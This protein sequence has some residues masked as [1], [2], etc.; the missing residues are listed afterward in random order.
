MSLYKLLAVALSVVFFSVAPTAYAATTASATSTCPVPVLYPFTLTGAALNTPWSLPLIGTIEGFNNT[1]VTATGLPPGIK[2]EDQKIEL[3]STSFKLHNWVLTGSPTQLGTYTINVTAQNSCGGTSTIITLPIN[4]SVSTVCP[5]G[6]TGQYPNCAPGTGPRV[7]IDPSAASFATPNPI[8]TGT[9]NTSSISITLQDS[10]GKRYNSQVV[11][12]VGARW[13]VPFYNLAGGTYDLYL[14][15]GD[16]NLLIPSRL[17]I[18]L[19]SAAT[20]VPPTSTSLSVSTP[21][22]TA[23]GACMSIQSTLRLGSRGTDVTALQNFLIGKGLLAGGSA[24]GYFGS[25][26][27]AA[28]QK[29]Q[30]GQ[31]LASSGDE[32][33][34]GYGLVGARTRAAIGCQSGSTSSS[35]QSAPRITCPAYPQP[36]CGVGSTLLGLGHD[37]NGCSM[38][39]QCLSQDAQQNIQVRGSISC[40]A[41]R[42]PVCYENDKPISL[43]TDANGCSLGSYCEQLSPATPV[44]L[45][46]QIGYHT[47]G[48]S[49][50]ANTATVLFFA[51][52]MSGTAPFTVSFY[53]SGIQDG[54]T[55]SIDYGDGSSSGSLVMPAACS[56]TCLAVAQSVTSTQHS[57]TSI[58]TYKATLK[59]SSGNTLGTVT[60]TS[61]GTL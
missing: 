2:L 15:D 45:I 57:Y 28:V 25:L 10:V 51:S 59:D 19:P 53:P 7:I 55:Y 24:S 61:Y 43:G 26:T 9:S 5:T 3:E 38:G 50:V 11:P 58:G 39:Y 30:A 8:V 6:T 40:P 32:N 47:S 4:N 52:P 27:R 20:P 46:C 60:I 42:T 56:G 33:S 48:S 36:V 44:I 35:V 14:Y 13:S 21:A 12:V 1:T 29:F 49:C 31:G 34:T 23:G 41:V 17:V 18:G 37:N 22:A 16:G 54:Q